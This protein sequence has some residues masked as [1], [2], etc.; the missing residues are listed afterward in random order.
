MRI[1]F[2]DMDGV[3]A[4]WKKAA[5]FEELYI[6]GYFRELPPQ[7]NV[8]DAI[9]MLVA[10]G[11]DV[12][13][14]SSY[15]QDHPTAILEKN[16]WLDRYMPSVPM[17]NRL[18]VPGHVHKG[19]WV[20]SNGI[21]DFR[22]DNAF[23]LDDYTV[24]LEDWNKRGGK[25]IKLLNDVNG[26]RGAYRRHA[27]AAVCY[28]DAPRRI[29][30]GIIEVMYQ[31]VGRQQISA[32]LSD[33]RLSVSEV[34]PKVLEVAATAYPKDSYTLKGESLRG[35]NPSK[36]ARIVA[37]TLE[38]KRNVKGLHTWMSIQEGIRETA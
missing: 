33:G 2:V 28:N 34:E 17:E 35:I 38:D 6:P 3:L 1:L 13:I 37:Q 21:C 12:R 27:I 19:A 15:L 7:T 23:L 24:N 25:G 26:T 20:Q 8:V 14:L 11:V 18:F 16:E 9:E 30:N 36:L 32:A 10:A 22:K 31:P 29:A 5:Q 4:V